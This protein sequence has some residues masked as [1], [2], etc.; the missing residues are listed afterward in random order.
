MRYMRMLTNSLMGGALGAAYLTILLL[1]LNPQV[2]LL[3]DA[4]P[5]W[6]AT[7]LLFYGVQLAVGFYLLLVLRELLGREPL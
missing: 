2:L 7:L 1:Q 6:G 3:S 4:G 5:G